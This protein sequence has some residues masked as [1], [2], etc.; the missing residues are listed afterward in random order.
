MIPAQIS[1]LY[2]VG[3]L[4]KIL[5]VYTHRVHR[6]IVG[7]YATPCNTRNLSGPTV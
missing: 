4:M 7:K 5:E 3:P 2:G 6:I 1:I